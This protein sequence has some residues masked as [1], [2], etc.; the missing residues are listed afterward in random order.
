MV[1]ATALPVP[2]QTSFRVGEL[3]GLADTVKDGV[4]GST[5]M[6]PHDLLA[7][8]LATCMS[9]TARMVAERAGLQNLQVSVRVEVEREEDETR[10]R[11]AVELDPALDGGVRAVVLAA[12]ER[13]PV[14]RTLSR[15][16]AF[17]P[18]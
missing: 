1:E 8:A 2:Y 13:C 15:P 3:E 10:F 17:L 11:Y 6:R 5:G 4:G 18:A 9:M 16:I 12:V 7:A 14:R